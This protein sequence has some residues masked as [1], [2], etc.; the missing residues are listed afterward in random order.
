MKT[1]IRVMSLFSGCGGMDLGFLLAEHPLYEYKMVW[2]NDFEKWACATYKR[3]LKHEI[4]CGDIWNVDL[5][6]TP[7]ADVVIGGFPCEDFSILRGD[8][9]PGFE[10]KRGLL[11]TKF[12][13]AVS[14]KQPLFFAAENVR[15]L[16]SAH[17]GWAIK[18]IK[19]D[20]EKVDHIGY[21]V[22]YKLIN[23]ADYGVPQN[24]QRVII[25]GIR[26]D[27][28]LKFVFP[29]PT[30][31]DR[32][33]NTRTALEGV[34]KVK[35][36]NEK[37]RMLDS[38]KKKIERIPP[39]GN[40]K[41]L[42]EYSGRNWMS[43]IYKRLHPDEPSPTIVACGGGGTWGYHYS[44]PRPLTNRERARLQTFPDNFQF[45]GPVGEVRKQIGN[46]VPPLGIKPVAE[47]ILEMFSSL[48]DAQHEAACAL[49][50]E[51]CQK[52]EAASALAR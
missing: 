2:A 33:V 43:L 50:A 5:D 26:N 34:E 28:N 13:E 20:F 44:E 11:Y 1:E 27:L 10:S 40:Y 6:K 29:Q 37:L 25:V 47:R 35:L 42:A 31:K 51:K 38:T 18:K 12:V 7:P 24:R 15:G 14:K 21:N 8:T 52:I 45:L 46:A 39:G 3:N 9:R 22:E 36:N 16:L 49:A 19:E 48:K 17:G 41:D 4:V 30:H 32:H 23:L